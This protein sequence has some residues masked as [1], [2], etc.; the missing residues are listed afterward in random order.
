[1]PKQSLTTKQIGDMGEAIAKKYLINKGYEIVALNYRYSRAEVDVIAT[2]NQ[3]LIF[4]E[5]KAKSYTYYGDPSE[6]VTPAKERMYFDAANKYME[7]L[8][9]EGEIRFDIIS[10]ILSKD[11]QHNINHFEDAFFA[12]L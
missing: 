3:A 4:I 12:G 11:G 6:S 2:Y 1:M 7:E 8:E 9:W 5:V 10:I